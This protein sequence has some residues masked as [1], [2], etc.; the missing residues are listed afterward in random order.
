MC[1][2]GRNLVLV[3]AQITLLHCSFTPA[4]GVLR[5]LNKNGA[6]TFP[7]EGCGIVAAVAWVQSLALELPHAMGTAKKYF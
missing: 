3:C 6:V 4:L 2:W 7:G 1:L 5:T